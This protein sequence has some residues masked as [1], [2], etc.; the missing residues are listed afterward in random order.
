MGKSI[1]KD[2]KSPVNAGTP[3]GLKALVGKAENKVPAITGTTVLRTDGKEVR[4]DVDDL[5]AKRAALEEASKQIEAEIRAID[6][7][8]MEGVLDRLT[9]KVIDLYEAETNR[10]VRN[11]ET[12]NKRCRELSAKIL[13]HGARNRVRGESKEYSRVVAGVIAAVE[14][15]D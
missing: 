7:E 12:N 9:D 10:I 2:G 13:G 3:S 5:D 6:R 1:L 14:S 4:K 15:A 8:Q 11:D